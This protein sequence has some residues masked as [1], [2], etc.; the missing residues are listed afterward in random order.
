MSNQPFYRNLRAF[1]PTRF[2]WQLAAVVG[3]AALI[4]PAFAG[5]ETHHESTSSSGNTRIYT[6]RGAIEYR[7]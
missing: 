3:A 7:F 6:L 4:A 1:S 2:R 5:T